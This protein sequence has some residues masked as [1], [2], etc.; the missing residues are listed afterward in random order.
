MYVSRQKY[1]QERCW[2]NSQQTFSACRT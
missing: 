2:E 1:N